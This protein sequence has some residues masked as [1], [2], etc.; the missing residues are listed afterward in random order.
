MKI[1]YSVGEQVEINQ[2]NKYWVDRTVYLVTKTRVGKENMNS[3]ESIKP[4]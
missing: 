2:K 3:T 1:N 4:Q